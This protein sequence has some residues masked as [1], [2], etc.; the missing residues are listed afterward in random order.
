MK[1]TLLILT[2]PLMSIV[3]G[4]ANHAVVEAEPEPRPSNP[5]TDKVLVFENNSELE[6][7]VYLE[8]VVIDP[9]A[10]PL[11]VQF[12]LVNKDSDP[13][14]FMYKVRW[15]DKNAIQVSDPNEVWRRGMIGGK[16]RLS[17]K[18]TAPNP[19]TVEYRLVLKE[20]E[21]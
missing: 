19:R 11:V 13:F 14:D 2:L 16:E 8:R 1:R 15:F 20:W 21:R 5:L 18:E 10:T 12:D 4:C 7:H 3:A 17:L 9:S 6:D